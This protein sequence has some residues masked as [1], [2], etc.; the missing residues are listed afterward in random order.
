MLPQS[1]PLT[2]QEKILSDAANYLLQKGELSDS[3][4]EI[5]KNIGTSHR[6]INYYFSGN[7]IF[8][9]AV[10][11]EIRK[12]EVQRLRSLKD[13]SAS[14]LDISSYISTLTTAEYKKVFSI[15][16][17]IYLKCIKD[18]EKFSDFKVS[19]IDSWVQSSS[20]SIESEM[21]IS[22][23]EAKNIARVRLALVRGI[24]MDF[25]ITNDRTALIE[26]CALADRMLLSLFPGK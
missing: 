14:P 1:T 26:A 6:M 7:D 9:E 16:L 18:P 8:W 23:Q 10:I 17:E 12:M 22:S 15:V 11:N 3:I 25:F 2:A 4:R 24:M 19:F 20:A 5:A 21:G 13:N